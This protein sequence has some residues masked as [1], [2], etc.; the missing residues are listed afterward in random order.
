MNDRTTTN[1]QPGVS[2]RDFVRTSAALAATALAGTAA[3]Q[4]AVAPSNTPAQKSTPGTG[5]RLKVGVIGCGGRGTGAAI[6]SLEASPD[7]EIYALADMF[8]DR[9]EG[10]RKELASQ[11]NG[12]VERAKVPDD[13]CFTGFDA[14]RKL[15]AVGEIDLVIL[16]T[17]PGFRPIHL[18]AAVDAGK[19]VFLEKPVAVD[20]TGIRSVLASAESASKKNLC[21]I[22]GTQRRHERCYL[23]A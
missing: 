4:N 10:C 15:L 3:A 1:G 13:H 14:Y 21:I 19:H 17:P 11:S 22:A 6:N 9:L 8:P 12:R 2:R 18:A 16:A 7:T 23:D 5:K 20:P